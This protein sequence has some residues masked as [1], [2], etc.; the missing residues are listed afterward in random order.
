MIRLCQ[1]QVPGDLTCKL[2]SVAASCGATLFMALM[3]TWQVRTEM[4]CKKMCRVPSID[5]LSQLISHTTEQLRSTSLGSTCTTQM[6]LGRYSRMEDIITL[7]TVANNLKRPDLEGVL[8]PF[9]NTVALRTDLSGVACSHRFLTSALPCRLPHTV[10]SLAILL[11]DGISVG[12]HR[13]AHLQAAAEPSEGQ[14]AERAGA[15][16]APLQGCAE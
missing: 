11:P 6:L 5:I 8:G 3:A 7:T 4:S 2:T 15:L 13:R 10:Y 14:R 16:R 1:S 9:S 12:R